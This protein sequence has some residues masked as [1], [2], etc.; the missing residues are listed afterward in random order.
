MIRDA[1]LHLITRRGE[2]EIDRPVDQADASAPGA[3]GAFGNNVQQFS[4]LFRTSLFG[5]AVRQD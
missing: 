5:T 1:P 4:R 3:I 2:S